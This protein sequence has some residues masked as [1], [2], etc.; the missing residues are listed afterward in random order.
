MEEILFLTA[1]LK[2]RIWGGDYFK[3]INKTTSNE[4]IGELWSAS[5]HK[6]GES[7][8]T[9]GKYKGRTLGDLFANE[10]QLFNL[11][12]K[13]FPILIKVIDA[14]EALSVQ[15][16]PNDEYSMKYEN[17][18]GKTEGWL[19]LDCKEDASI[20]L[21][22]NASN[23]EE[24]VK[25]IENNDY[26]NLLT[27]INV[28]KGQFFPIYAGTVH[29]IG[30]GITILEVQQSSDV[31]YRFYDYNR[32]DDKGNTREL[33]VDQAVAV[34]TYDKPQFSL[35]NVLEKGTSQLWNNDYFSVDLIDV[36]NSFNIVKP[37]YYSIITVAEGEF[38][39]DGNNLSLGDSFIV[40]SEY[41]NKE[42]KGNGKLVLTNPNKA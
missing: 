19:I 1:P 30:A 24:L 17:Q 23:K 33:H 36:K 21:G 34:T 13:E 40:T 22:T 26:D 42:M 37:K 3:K 6:Q 10:Q 16:H 9:N 27:K 28:K 25:Y 11:A 7:I 5:A 32:K 15:V 35:D 20:V 2:E 4:A 12:D 39:L 29:A 41:Q 38:T 14:K 18:L 31:T 8:I